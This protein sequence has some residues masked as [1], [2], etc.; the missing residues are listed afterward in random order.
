VLNKKSLIILLLLVLPLF[1]QLHAST[2][3]KT[4]AFLEERGLDPVLILLL[5]S[6]FPIIELRGAIP[7]GIFLFGMP[8]PKVVILSIIGNMIPIPFLLLLL[9][10]AF[11]ILERFKWGKRFTTWLYARTRRKGKVI[12]RFQA[13]GLT[14]F[15]GIPLPGTGAWTGSLAAKIF[16][17]RFWNAMLY[18]FLGVVM[19]AA[20]VTALSLAGLMAV[21]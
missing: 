14:V 10:S 2:T 7:V 12:E 1:A 18:I 15:V 5:I 19:A 4:V 6:A 8:W 16:G 11:A 21:S 17:I 3:T 20:I 9:D 13:I